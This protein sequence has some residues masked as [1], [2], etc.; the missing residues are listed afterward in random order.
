M[1]PL[2]QTELERC[3]D[4]ARAAGWPA[5]QQAVLFT[6]AT[7]LPTKAPWL[8]G[9]SAALQQL[10]LIIGGLGQRPWS[11]YA[12]SSVKIFGGRRAAQLV[13]HLAPSARMFVTDSH[14]TMLTTNPVH[15]TIEQALQA[16][17]GG[18]PAV[19][20]NAEC[21][22]WPKCYE[23]IYRQYDAGFESCVKKGLACYV[24][25]G[26]YLA[27]SAVVMRQMYERQIEMLVRW[28]RCGKA[29]STYMGREVGLTERT[30]DQSQLHF[31]W[32]NRSRN[33]PLPFDLALDMNSTFFLSLAACYGPNPMK[34][35]GPM[36]ACY[37]NR[38]AAS[39]RYLK[40]DALNSSEWKG[41]E[42]SPPGRTA[43]RPLVL[44]ANGEGKAR[45]M[46]PSVLP[47]TNASTLW[48]P[49][50]A[51]L[52]FPVLLLDEHA[53]FRRRVMRRSTGT[54]SDSSADAGG[55]VCRVAKLGDL[56]VQRH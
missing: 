38:Y 27:S 8:L 10:P 1:Q 24:N 50:L 16:A 23:D 13:D 22:S 28:K 45:M 34:R 20:A 12:D 51:M 11:W 37:A 17:S 53:A 46:H 2:T 39:T 47:L 5:Q 54:G 55:L 56:I 21:A 31:M 33:K 18:Q 7:S 4:V 41:A 14:D 19:L 40:V 3:A 35:L 25:S 42:F 49:S 32:V 36:Q 44:H 43:Q 52:D 29:C 6:Y 26:G 9:L 30:A 15:A 48:S